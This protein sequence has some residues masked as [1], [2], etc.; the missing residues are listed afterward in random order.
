M[1]K[2]I[3]IT[4]LI[5][6]LAL[7]ITGIQLLLPHD[8]STD[9]S[10]SMAKDNVSTRLAEKADPP[11]YPKRMHEWAGYLFM[12]AGVVHIYLNRRAINS[13]LKKRF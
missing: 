1:R 13:Y 12:L 2:I 7:S 4:L 8:R 10:V 11:F 5:T 9:P 6:Y 3:S